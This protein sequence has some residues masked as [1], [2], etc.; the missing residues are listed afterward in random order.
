M[1]GSMSEISRRSTVIMPMEEMLEVGKQRVS[2]TI[3]VPREISLQENR[4]MLVPEGVR[5]LVNNGHKVLIEAGAGE[6]GHFHDL[7]FSQAGALIVYSP[8][9]VFKSDVIL[10]VAPPAAAEMELLK[11]KQ[12]LLSA[13]HMPM[14]KEE[15]FRT[16][17]S[18]KVTGLA[19]EMIRD[20]SG[21]L[22][23]IRAMSE[24]AGC[25]SIFIAAEYLAC[26]EK[27]RAKMF[28]GFTGIPP[29]EVVIIGAG[30]VGE[31][32]ARSAI[33]LGAMV[34]I[35][36][37]SVYRL[38]RMQGNLNIRVF[39]SILQPNTLVE[40]LRSADVL[41]G[42]IRSPGGKSPCVITEQMVTGMKEGA[43]LIDV[44]IDQGGCI[45]T[46]KP[47]THS[48]PVFQLHGVTHYCVPNIPSRVPHT[49]S[50]ALNNLFVPVLLDAGAEGGFE[51][52][53]RRDAG[54]RQG[55]YLYNGTV[56]NLSVSKTFNLPFQD[57]E[58]LMA[59]FQ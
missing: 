19:L 7:E 35:F 52:L 34:K 53:I 56:T 26:P 2:L 4:I 50:Q 57:I 10:K 3:G 51:H 59:A 42:A 22:S 13:L 32:A 23:V 21:I 5:L 11:H 37:N 17:M 20:A 8:E 30:T 55:V 47:T 54:L 45:E 6:A 25:E 9:E 36:D 48:N 43:I 28:G 46:S 1:E 18:K 12:V 58:L 39:T 29:T 41:I 14:Q 38:R 49:A 31:Y 44:S 24:I 27:G 33:G 15:Y 40:A 16:L